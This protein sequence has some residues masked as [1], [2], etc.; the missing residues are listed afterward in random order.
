M[1]SNDPTAPA[2]TSADT[3][4]EVT[5]DDITQLEIEEKNAAAAPTRIRDNG[6]GHGPTA[7]EA[8]VAA[9]RMLAPEGALE[10]PAVH[11][12]AVPFIPV[13]PIPPIVLA[14]RAVSGR[15]GATFGAW[16][17]D[18]RVDVDGARPT[19]RVSGDFFQTTGGTV[20]YFGS[21]VVNAISLTVTPTMVTISGIAD[22]TW[23][24]SFNQLKVT[25]PRVSILSPS[26]SA[27]VQ[28][29]NAAS[30]PGA[31]YLAAYVSR[32]LRSV[33]LEQ[34]CETGI[35]PFTSYNT[36]ALPS[37]GP[38]RNLTIAAAYAEASIEMA[39]A[40]VPNIIGSAPG[41]TWDDNELH[42]A[43]VTHFSLWQ[44]QPHWKV[45]LFHA[46]RYVSPSVLGIM[47]DQQGKQR[48]GCACFY[49]HP[50][51][52]GTTATHLRT[53]LYCC[54]HELGHCFN[55]FHSFHKQYMTPPMPNRIGA[56]SWMN[57]PP[58]Y[59]P[60][61]GAGGTAAFWAAFPFQF[62]DLELIHL[63]HA[64]R[65]NVIMGGN[66]FGTGAALESLADFDDPIEDRSGLKLELR[67]DRAFKLG[68][69]VVVELKL[70]AP[71]GSTRQVHPH[72]HPNATFV[73][74]AVQKPGGDVVI[75]EPVLEQCVAVETTQLT[76]AR[77]AIY[78]S[79]Y[80]GYGKHG[81]LFDQP[82]TYRVRALYAAL[83]GS[84]ILSN[85]LELKV[86]APLTEEDVQV[87]DLLMGDEQ[88]LLFYLLGSDSEHL[89]RGNA[90]LRE[91][92]EKYAAHPLSLYARLVSGFAIARPF[93]KVAADGT[94]TVRAPNPTEAA[95]LLGT[96][97]DESE[98][99][100]GVDN[101]TLSQTQCRL[102]R[103]HKEAG[104]N[105]AAQDAVTRMTTLFKSKGLKPHVLR[106]I[107]AQ[108]NAA[109]T[110]T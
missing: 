6:N 71:G 94:M 5:I 47:F 7:A 33:S 86:R 44:D 90:A 78:V 82:G 91:L 41:S 55:L 64:Y 57:Y 95:R 27:T 48:Q 32:L 79:A 36:G 84:R 65:N 62:D 80:I 59:A 69:P 39:T 8:S 29:F 37:G 42:N 17:L 70:S 89:S 108:G 76:T 83:D 103:T 18:L 52:D 101:L 15:Y 22:T 102:A 11:G 106:S 81:L 97:I 50:M 60:S 56:L 12:R 46:S 1:N 38:A 61:G 63:R 88:G 25:I 75:H 2:T 21:F 98:K 93:K 104:D 23:A 54:V 96:V 68:E 100:Q 40:G 43:M 92:A 3:M 35:T 67:T 85:T 105:K 51:M 110:T 66:P 109:L 53:Q 14:R 26:A 9:E 10:A 28:W 31:T 30:S 87:A 49:R 19:K 74:L 4:Q 58:Q 72:L 99:G 24:T 45:W 73:R 34:D 20:S 16:Q 77:P 13:R 107:A